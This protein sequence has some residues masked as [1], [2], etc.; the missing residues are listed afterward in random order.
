MPMV[1]FNYSLKDERNYV[2]EFHEKFG[3]AVDQPFSQELL[4]LRVTLIKEE[5]KEFLEAFRDFSTNP[6]KGCEE[7][8]LKEICDVIYVILGTLVSFGD[9]RSYVTDIAT[10]HTT[11]FR[12]SLEELIEQGYYLKSLTDLEELMTLGL[13]VVLATAH[14][15]WFDLDGAFKEVHKSNMTKLWED[16]KPRYREDGKVIKPEWY[17]PPNLSDYVCSYD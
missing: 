7:H 15:L 16:G 9:T 1:E 13:E 8:L 5:V 3:L 12:E 14:G 6:T 17:E 2:K 11:G 4:D 10:Y